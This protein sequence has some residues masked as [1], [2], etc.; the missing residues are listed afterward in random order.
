MTNL[1]DNNAAHSSKR[2]NEM[3]VK[4]ETFDFAYINLEK[5]TPN[6]FCTT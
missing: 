3:A 4:G 5:C 1:D 6:E 2:G